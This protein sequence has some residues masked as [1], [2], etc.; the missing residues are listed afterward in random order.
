MPS[1]GEPELRVI[2]GGGKP[3]SCGIV[4]DRES[5]A[6]IWNEIRPLIHK[7]MAATEGEQTEAEIFSELLS[8]QMQLWLGMAG[9]DVVAVWTTK[10]RRYHAM[11]VCY[12]NYAASEPGY[13]EAMV[14]W[15]EQVCDWAEELGCDQV[16]ILG[17]K[18]WQKKLDWRTS[19]LVYVKDL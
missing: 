19:Q 9:D 6:N 4:P 2:E 11:H 10:L 8:N 12:G 13:L 1:S 7:A 3:L 17:R 16:Q 18:G 5:I 15:F 14:K